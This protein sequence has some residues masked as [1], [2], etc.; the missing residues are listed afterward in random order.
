MLLALL[1][2]LRTQ[3]IHCLDVNH[4]NMSD[5]KCIFYLTS[6]QKHSRPGKQQKPIELEAFGQEPNLCII[7]HLK[8]YVDKTSVHS[9]DTD[10]SQLQLSFQKPFK[11]VSNDTV[12]RWIKNVLKDAGIDTTKFGAHSTRAASPSAAAKVA[13]PLEVFL[14]SAG[15]SNCGAFAKFYQ[16]PINAPFNFGSVLLEANTVCQTYFLLSLFMTTGL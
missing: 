11:P 4:M 12:A 14:E 1:T 10:S 3:T 13:T 16:K 7:R 6:L 8:E 2:G 9:G 5:K 15:W